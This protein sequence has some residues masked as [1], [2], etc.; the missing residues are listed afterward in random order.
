MSSEPA[1]TLPTAP[2][3]GKLLVLSGPSGSGKSSVIQRALAAGDLPVRLAVSATTR[4]PRPNER[5]GVHYHFWS[6]ER[7]DQAVQAGEFLEWAHV[8][9]HRYGTLRAEVD[10]H[11]RAGQCVLLEID[12]QG[13]SQIKERCPE[14]VLIFVRASSLAE[15]ERRLRARNTDDEASLQRRL[16]SAARE[17]AIGDRDYHHQIINDDLDSAVEQF[18][19]LVRNY[20]GS[21]HAR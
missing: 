16:Q 5:D 21:P 15:Y 17:M 12:V 2:V 8:Y 20:G 14:S 9:G 1:S 11:L 13:G 3:P 6:P 18:R 10:R 7:F 19:A 4:P